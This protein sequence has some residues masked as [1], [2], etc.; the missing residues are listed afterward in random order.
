MGTRDSTQQDMVGGPVTLAWTLYEKY[1][2]LPVLARAY[3][4]MKAYVA[5]A[6]K[7]N[8]GLV[9]SK[10]RGFGDWCP[11]DRGPN[12]NGGQGRPDI[13]NCFSEQAVVNTAL[14]YLQTVDTAKAAEALG[15]SD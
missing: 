3:P 1:G 5:T 11:P 7:V 13:G 15:H 4:G 10:D 14:F 8:P 6:A 9:W 12:V 2:A